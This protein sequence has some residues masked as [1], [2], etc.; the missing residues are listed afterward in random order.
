MMMGCTLSEYGIYLIKLG[1]A[2]FC[3]GIVG[4]ERE[5]HEKAAGFKTHIL[6]CLG[7]CLFTICGIEIVPNAN[8]SELTRVI[9]GIVT[10]VGFAGA[11]SIIREGNN[12]KGVTTA[13]GIWVMAAI[14]ICIGIGQYG[15]ALTA[16]IAT[17]FTMRFL[18]AVPQ[19]RK[20]VKKK[21]Y[22]SRETRR[23]NN[24]NNASESNSAGARNAKSTGGE[25]KETD[26]NR[27]RDKNYK[28]RYTNPNR[29]NKQY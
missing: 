21:K 27:T 13:A 14:G 15:L 24:G 20:Y 12:V 9:Q 19:K 5:L 16:T 10:G 6:I 11:G 28:R 4:Y 29:R 8:V 25:D 1:L 22:Y 17:F 7:S 26:T 23:R 18:R 2:V 3:A